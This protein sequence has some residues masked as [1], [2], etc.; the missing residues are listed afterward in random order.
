M[1]IRHDEEWQKKSDTTSLKPQLSATDQYEQSRSETVS[2]QDSKESGEHSS[3]HWIFTNPTTSPLTR[4]N[5]K[6]HDKK[7]EPRLDG[8]NTDPRHQQCRIDDLQN[9]LSGIGLELSNDLI[10]RMMPASIGEP[11]MKSFLL[12][13]NDQTMQEKVYNRKLSTQE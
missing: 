11:P 6:K 7:Q 8:R 4:F 3:H 10:A 5:L 12:E 1:A 2:S 9:A 13:K